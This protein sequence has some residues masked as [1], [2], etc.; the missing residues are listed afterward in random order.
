MTLQTA[1]TYIPEHT[2][3]V[4]VCKAASR[5]NDQNSYNCKLFSSLPISPLKLNV[6]DSLKTGYSLLEVAVAHK[7][8]AFPK[9]S[10]GSRH[11]Y[12]PGIEGQDGTVAVSY[13][14]THREEGK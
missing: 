3:Y 10:V 4:C 7:V 2:L 13:R 6:P 5:V 14:S 12:N 11:Q 8:K 9:I 1:Y